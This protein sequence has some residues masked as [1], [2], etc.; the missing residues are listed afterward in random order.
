MNQLTAI[1]SKGQG[2]EEITSLE[3]RTLPKQSQRIRVAII[4]YRDD[5]QSGGSL[6][7]GETLANHLDPSKVDAHLI[8]AYGG[9]GPVA[10]HARVPCHFL[11]AKGPKDF[12]A[13]IRA[14]HFF[15]KLEP[16]LLHFM[17]GVI[18]LR[19]ALVGKRYVRL[20]HVHGK[21]LTQYL[22]WRERVIY[23]LLFGTADGHVCIS[24]GASRTLI[25]LGWSRPSRTWT[26]RNA[27]D[28][29]FFSN[30]PSRRTSRAQL[31]IPAGAKLLA[32]VCTLVKHRGCD[33]AIKLLSRLD[34]QWHLVFCGDGPFRSELRKLVEDQDLQHRVHFVGLMDDVRGIYAASDAYLL[35][36]RYDSFGLAVCQAMAAGVPV[37]GL[38]GD[39]EYR[40]LEYPLI[41][42]DNAVLVQRRYPFNY[43]EP[44]A[45]EVLDELAR[46]IIQY[47]EHPKKYLQMAN[48]AR[49]WIAERFDACIQAEAVS[50]LYEKVLVG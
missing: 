28:V 29:K 2:H 8:F 40:E 38:G 18:W 50:N 44:E 14:R 48:R 46:R 7:V 6:R 33:D 1:L 13:W 10:R 35:M 42:P 27:I 36:A 22:R 21:F 31:G 4:H 3:M 26:I 47:G 23:R 19:C 12:P 34:E 5:A 9:P 41:T 43:D 20:M 39:G 25:D 49:A 30:L 24:N 17:D 11:G 15:R 32:M 37:F 45:P 16:D